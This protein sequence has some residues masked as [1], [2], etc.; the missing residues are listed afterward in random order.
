MIVQGAFQVMYQQRVSRDSSAMGRIGANWGMS[1]QLQTALNCH[2]NIHVQ[3]YEM[4][5]EL[6][7]RVTPV[8]Q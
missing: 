5:L 7:W 8:G 4:V 1:D 3:G 6:D 2:N